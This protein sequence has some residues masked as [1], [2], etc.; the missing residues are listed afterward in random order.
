M[1]YA[2]M[3]E[4]KIWIVLENLVNK[5]TKTTSAPQL[6]ILP[7]CALPRNAF[8]LLSSVPLSEE[9]KREGG[10]QRPQ[11]WPKVICNFAIYSFPRSWGQ[12]AI[13]LE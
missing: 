9:G 7:T 5:V 10:R 6:W 12:R 13:V 3:A 8:S 4:H 11:Q 2:K 1:A